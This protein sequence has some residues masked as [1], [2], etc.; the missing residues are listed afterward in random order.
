MTWLL[1][2]SL[3]LS[4]LVVEWNKS[5]SSHIIHNSSGIGPHLLTLGGSSLSKQER[6]DSTDSG[7]AKHKAF[8]NNNI[9]IHATPGLPP[10]AGNARGR[11]IRRNERWWRWQ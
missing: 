7:S 2:D 5:K 8:Y 4:G 1:H 3:W 6:F 9:Y 11:P 10:S